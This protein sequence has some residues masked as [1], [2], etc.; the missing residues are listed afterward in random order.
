MSSKKKLCL[1]SVRN[2]LLS[3]IML[4]TIHIMPI[5]FVLSEQ[6]CWQIRLYICMY[7]YI[8]RPGSHYCG[9]LLRGHGSQSVFHAGKRFLRHYKNA[10]A[11]E[12]HGAFALFNFPGVTA[13]ASV[14]CF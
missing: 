10:G 9:P 11:G 3:L 14:L 4:Q 12:S 13:S 1:F 2:L 6:F 8:F 7:Y 5:F